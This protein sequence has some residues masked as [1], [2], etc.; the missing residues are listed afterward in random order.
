[1]SAAPESARPRP[2]VATKFRPP[3]N[4]GSL[5]QRPHLVESL[6]R[7]LDCKLALVHGPAGFGK[8]T[9][10]TQWFWQLRGQGISAAWLSV[11]ASDNDLDRFLGYLT[12]AVRTAEPDI[13]VGLRE[14]IEANPGSATDFVLDTLAKDLAVHEAPLV[15]FIDDWHLIRQTSVHEA[16]QLLLARAPVNLHFVV[17][18]RTRGGVPLAR[19]RVQNELI[20]ID[21][22]ALRF[23]LEESRSYLAMGRSPQLAPDDVAALWRSTEGWAAALQLASLSLRSSVI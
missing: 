16:L 15:L 19:L 11:D 13:G 10:A 2:L 22:A 9:L 12:E 8:T 23:D 21:A 4:R 6:S 18:S 1:M 5:I 7:T 20:E 14:T 3:A 17:T